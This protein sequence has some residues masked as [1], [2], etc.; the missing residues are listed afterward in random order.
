[1]KT[2]DLGVKTSKIK[3]KGPGTQTSNKAI[4]IIDIAAFGS[5][6]ILLISSRGTCSI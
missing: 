6:F 1:M 3:T 2:L 4:K 5:V